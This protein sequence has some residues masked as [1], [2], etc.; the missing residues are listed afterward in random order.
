METSAP[1]AGF[2]PTSQW[3][4]ERRGSLI[5]LRFRK[6]EASCT[7]ISLQQG[8]PSKAHAHPHRWQTLILSFDR[9]KMKRIGLGDQAML[10]PCVS[11]ECRTACLDWDLRGTILSSLVSCPIGNVG[12]FTSLR[13]MFT[14]SFLRHHKTNSNFLDYPP[15]YA[16]TNY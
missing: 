16:E 7:A 4:R 2:C 6:V 3:R 8:A 1:S 11:A 10:T 15:E 5:L 9:Q 13:A 12:S 14:S